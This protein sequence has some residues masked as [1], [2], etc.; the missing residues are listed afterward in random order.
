M[1]KQAE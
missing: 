1:K